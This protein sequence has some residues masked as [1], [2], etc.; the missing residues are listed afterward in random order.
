MGNKQ[1]EKNEV[2]IP[3]LNSCKWL[4]KQGIILEY[5]RLDA[6]DYDHKDGSPDIEIRL[7]KDEYVW[8]LMVEC[9]A[10]DGTGTQRP[11]QIK[12]ENKYK[13]VKNVVY[14]LVESVKE[15]EAKVEE[16]T[17]HWAGVQEKLKLFEFEPGQ[18]IFR[19]EM[20]E[21]EIY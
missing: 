8:L 10:P 11:S 9:K 7:I 3:C 6:M 20:T 19:T 13:A 4:V 16:L 18:T 21:E 12:Y 17:K 5:K 2:L 1:L 14:I 15:M